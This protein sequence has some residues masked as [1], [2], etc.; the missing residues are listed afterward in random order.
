MRSTLPR[1]DHGL[2]WPNFSCTLWH[3]LQPSLGLRLITSTVKKLLNSDFQSQFSMSKMV[4]IFLNLFFIDKYHCRN[5]FF[6]IDIFWKIQFSKH[7]IFWNDV[8][9]LTTFT[10][11]NTR[12]KYFLVLSIKDSPTK[13]AKVCNQSVV[14]LARVVWPNIFL[15]EFHEKGHNFRSLRCFREFMVKMGHIFRK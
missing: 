1:M 3:I 12:P 9:F 10:Q 13:C 7:F 15:R 6:V 8:Q 11:L 2:V 14:K 4:W 5:R